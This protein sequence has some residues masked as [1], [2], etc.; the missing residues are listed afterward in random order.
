[1]AYHARLTLEG[2]SSTVSV[3]KPRSGNGMKN[4]KEKKHLVV[5]KH[6][7][8]VRGIRKKD[9]AQLYNFNKIF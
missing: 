6:H 2:K 8:K 3:T 7:K 1:M 4:T 9:E 5:Q